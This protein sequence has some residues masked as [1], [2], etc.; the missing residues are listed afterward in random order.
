MRIFDQVSQDIHYGLRTLRRSPGF[1]IVA[2]LTLALGIGA[3]TAIFSVVDAILLKML[4]VR[5]PEE[6]I[7]V[8]VR[9]RQQPFDSYRFSY[10]LFQDVREGGRSLVD[11]FAAGGTGLWELTFTQPGAEVRPEKVRGEMVSGSYFTDLGVQPVLGR[12]L[13]EDD[14]RTRGGHPVAVIS[15][16]LWT[17]RFGNS[18]EVVGRTFRLNDTLFTIVGITPREFFGF[19]PGLAPEVWVPMVMQTQVYP[20]RATLDNYNHSWMAVMGRLKPGVTH[21]QVTAAMRVKF[22]QSLEAQAATM[23]ERARQQ[24]FDQDIRVVEG[25][26]GLDQVRKRFSQPLMILTVVVGLVL[27]IAC[28]N[29]ANLLLARASARK[30]EAAVRLALG[31]GR[32]RLVRQLLTESA[33]LAMIGGALGL[34]LAYGGA[35][36]LVNLVSAGPFPFVLDVSP[37]LR[38]LGFNAAVVLFA[39]MLFGV[40][41]ALQGSRADLRATLGGSFGRTGGK[42]GMRARRV[43]T[44]VQVAFSLMLLVG[45]GLFL[46]T[47]YNLTT[48][49][50]GFNRD[51]LL[52]VRLMPSDNGYALPRGRNVNEQAR[53]AAVARLQGLYSRLIE[54]IEA[55]PGVR[56]ATLAECGQMAGCNNGRCC[57]QVEGY[58]PRQDEE[59]RVGYEI[60]GPRYFETMGM[61]LLEGRD[62]NAGDTTGAPDV[63]VINETMARYYFGN[64]S[65]VGKRFQFDEPERI[66]IIG[67]VKDTKNNSVREEA[68]NF[69]YFPVPQQI[70]DMAMLSVRTQG[71]PEALTAQVV[72]AIEDVDA[73][74]RPLETQTLNQALDNVISQERLVAQLSSFFGL[75][76]LAL[77]CVGLYGLV[78]YSVVRRTT[79]IGLRSALG[80]QKSDI[81]RLILREDLR[82]VSLGLLLGIAGAVAT[83]RLARSL[84]FELEPNDPPTIAAAALVMI[85][86]ALLAGYLPARRAARIHPMSALRYE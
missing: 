31:A 9:A 13:A 74:V 35:D 6:L 53:K 70:S 45:A 77:T 57:V 26:S 7:K 28:V 17:S 18:P 72:Q 66:E 8:E 86:V 73:R 61:T 54:R 39:G 63:V 81:L 33:L 47:L 82:L 11:V 75:V 10:P 85:A 80:A 50:V 2:V 58:T 68:E 21:E 15:H 76:A 44:V 20:G 14:A 19:Q 46:R 59:R 12:L 69:V 1:T 34:A 4:P 3:N 29:V 38:V 27:L 22:R 79:E 30:R 83:T 24:F 36:L 64:A 32:G 23:P 56:S 84:L 52:M 43:L 16:R 55:I 48:F 67:V 51:N 25:R 41:P 37:D 71:A 42:H 78:A 5:S 40:A 62:F 60:V 65:A 49:D